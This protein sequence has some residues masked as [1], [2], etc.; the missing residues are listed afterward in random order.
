LAVLAAFILSAAPETARCEGDPVKTVNEMLSGMKPEQRM[1][2]AFLVGP[3]DVLE[4]SVWNDETLTREVIV[5]PDGFI[6]FP[7]IGEVRAEGRSVDDLRKAVEEKMAEY[8]P[9]VPVT[10]MLRQLGS[11]RVYVI[12]KVQ[13]PGAFMLQ[14]ETRVI[15]VLSMAGGPTTF[16]DKG[17]IIVIRYVGD[18]EQVFEFDYD[19]VVRGE[20]LSQNIL[21][22]PGDTVVVP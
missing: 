2:E 3:G 7:L 16:A 17:D 4:V 22:Q 14:D 21:L 12:G 10:V 15:Q 18:G 9:D 8:V 20:N 13:A 1:G 19:E 6:S 11:T 5:R